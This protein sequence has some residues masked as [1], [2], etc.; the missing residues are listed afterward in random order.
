MARIVLAS[1]EGLCVGTSLILGQVCRLHQLR[2]RRFLE[3]LTIRLCLKIADSLVHMPRRP[4]FAKTGRPDR[5]S[6]TGSGRQR[7]VADLDPDLFYRGSRAIRPL[8]GRLSY[9]C[10]SRYRLRQARC[11]RRHRCRAGQLYH[12]GGRVL[13]RR[14]RAGRYAVSDKEVT[15]AILAGCC[16]PPAPFDISEP[17]FSASTVARDENG[18][19]FDGSMFEIFLSRKLDR[20][21][22]QLVCHL[23]HCGLESETSG[24]LAGA[25]W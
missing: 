8:S 9:K 23:V 3:P 20:I 4:Q 11:W 12:C 18:L 6:R 5:A 22:F 13:S 15:A 19:P 14:I 16:L 7:R 2:D 10:R 21:H 1:G 25:R 24:R 17:R